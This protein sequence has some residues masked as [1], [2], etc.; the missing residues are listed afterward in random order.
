LQWKLQHDVSKKGELD[1]ECLYFDE[2]PERRFELAAKLQTEKLS[3]D[4]KDAEYLFVADFQFREEF[5]L[6]LKCDLLAGG[7]DRAYSFRNARNRED[8]AQRYL[9]RFVRWEV[10]FEET[11]HRRVTVLALN[12]HG[13][14]HKS[15]PYRFS[16][17]W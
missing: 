12:V 15:K 9:Q 13:F 7:Q 16:P 2:F 1:S 11:F 4:L 10:F 8:A 14:R 17:G 5:L 6:Q 3:G